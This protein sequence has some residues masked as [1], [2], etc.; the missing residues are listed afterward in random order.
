[1]TDASL[2][3]ALDPAR[4]LTVFA[5]AFRHPGSDEAP[6]EGEAH[7]ALLLAQATVAAIRDRL[8]RL[9]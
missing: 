2:N 5:S 9:V 1:M 4:D 7:D 3:E 8:G 6:P